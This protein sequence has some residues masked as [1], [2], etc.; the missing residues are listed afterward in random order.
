MESLTFIQHKIREIRGQKVI[1]DRDLAAMYGVETKVLNQSVKRNIERFPIDF[2]FQLDSQEVE[3]LRS[4][5]VTLKTGRG[6]HSK[7]LPY[8]F[9][10]HGVTMLSSILKS[11]TA[12]QVNI[13]V[14]RAFVAMR[15]M[16]TEAR[17]APMAQLEEKIDKL[18]KYVEDILKDQNDINEDV[19]MQLDNISEVIAELQAQ[20]KPNMPR[21]RIGFITGD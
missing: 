16:V 1:L 7:Y 2:M 17:I 5:I 19:Q 8:A 21:K 10:E 11:P 6:Q 12:V 9:T 3:S 4:Q 13:A 18:A 15:K 20:Q 14:V